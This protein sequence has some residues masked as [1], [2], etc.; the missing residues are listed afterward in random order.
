[1]MNDQTRATYALAP[2]PAHQRRRP[3]LGAVLLLLLVS[4]MLMACAAPLGATHPD[5]PCAQFVRNR[6]PTIPAYDQFVTWSRAQRDSLTVAAEQETPLG[7]LVLYR[8]TCPGEAATEGMNLSGFYLLHTPPGRQS[9]VIAAD[10]TPELTSTTA[11]QTLT[12]RHFRREGGQFITYV[13]GQVN[14]PDVQSVEATLD[15]GEV[16]SAT[17]SEHTFVLL[18][19]GQRAACNLRALD[20]AGTILAQSSEQT[21]PGDATCP[22]QD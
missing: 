9:S 11:I 5:E 14:D 16:V 22:A 4:M 6:Y 18:V 10:V 1:M 17:L 12:S 8:V 21:P 19:E 3:V 15:T 7:Q 13:L 2:G 20:A